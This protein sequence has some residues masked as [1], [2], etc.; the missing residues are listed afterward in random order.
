MRMN[1]ALRDKDNIDNIFA[2]APVEAEVEEI[3]R[4]L[5]KRSLRPSNTHCDDCDDEI[6]EKRRQLVAGCE[7]CVECEELHARMNP[8]RR[9][10][11][12]DP[13]A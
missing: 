2:E 7:R 5:A 3:R 10:M 8:P 4:A 13:G 12:I 1:D 6:P 9:G 11:T